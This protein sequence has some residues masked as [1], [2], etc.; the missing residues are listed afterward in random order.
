MK[1]VVI[2]AAMLSVLTATA[3]YAATEAGGASSAAPPAAR[4]GAEGAPGGQGVKLASAAASTF[5][6]VRD[7]AQS[8]LV[9]SARAAKAGEAGG[10]NVAIP[11]ITSGAT[12]IATM[13]G[14]FTAGRTT[15][16]RIMTV[17]TT[18]GRTGTD[19]TLRFF[20]IRKSSSAPTAACWRSPQG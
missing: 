16:G 10:G 1:V 20:A 15:V 13:S 5:L 6:F 7:A 19:A 17:R 12:I 14:Q 9:R 8:H 18:A 11:P 2:S 4:S 3:S